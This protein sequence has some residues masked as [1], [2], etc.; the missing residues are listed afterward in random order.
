M[1]DRESVDGPRPLE[2]T[3]SPKEADVARDDGRCAGDVNW[4]PTL[5]WAAHLGLRAPRH[6]FLACRDP[7]FE[8]SARS[9]RPTGQSGT[10]VEQGKAQRRS[11]GCGEFPPGL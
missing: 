8:P 1:P 2:R 5:P 11:R 4:S 9:N 10:D 3:F 7:P 6:T